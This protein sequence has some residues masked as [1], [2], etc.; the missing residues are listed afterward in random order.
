MPQHIN[1]IK[2]RRKELS[3]RSEEQQQKK[4]K[5]ASTLPFPVFFHPPSKP[6]IT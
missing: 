6:G 4:K 1:V 3:K 2:E 5:Y